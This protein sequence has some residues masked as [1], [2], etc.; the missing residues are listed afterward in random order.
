VIISMLWRIATRGLFAKPNGRGIVLTPRATRRRFGQPGNHGVVLSPWDQDGPCIICERSYDGACICP[1]C[2]ICGE[3]GDLLCYQEHGMVESAF[4]IASRQEALGRY[5]KEAEAEALMLDRLLIQVYG[6]S[7][8]HVGVGLKNGGRQR[9]PSTE[10][11]QSI[12]QLA[13][14]AQKAFDKGDCEEAIDCLSN[15][16]SDREAAVKL[17]LEKME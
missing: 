13:V 1:V 8:H 12:A 7:P 16:D 11:L 4:Q 15:I 2:P 9:Q 6:K 3:T 17:V 10:H 14:A 5:R